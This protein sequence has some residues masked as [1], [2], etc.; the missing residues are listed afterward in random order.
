MYEHLDD[1]RPYVPDKTVVVAE[2]GRR[3]RAR[4]RVIAATAT[5]PVLLVAGG[6]V[7]LR[8]QADQ[9]HR[10]TI[11]GLTPTRAPVVAPG[12]TSTPSTDKTLLTA[13]VNILLVGTDFPAGTTPD[14]ALPGITRADA[15]AIVR[16]DPTHHRLAVLSIPRDAWVSQPPGPDTKLGAML[17]P[18]PTRL[19]HAVASLTGLEINH[20]ISVD[21]SGFRALID[22]AGGVTVPFQQSVIAPTPASKPPP[23]APTSTD[24]RH[25]PTCAHATSNRSTPSQAAPGKT[26]APTTGASPVGKTSS[27]VS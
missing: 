12:D 14:P 1:D 26:P 5:V 21:F 6:L 9:L 2:A 13:P 18:D 22:L 4:H 8:S 25:S 10:R 20:Y 17:T 16:L 15:I 7:Y 23:D 3:I 24:N 19:V 11:G 27:A